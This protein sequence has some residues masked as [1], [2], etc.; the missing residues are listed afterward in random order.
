MFYF[1]W[2]GEDIDGKRGVCVVRGGGGGGGGCG[3]AG[4]VVGMSRDNI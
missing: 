2:L 1:P 4:C 3:F